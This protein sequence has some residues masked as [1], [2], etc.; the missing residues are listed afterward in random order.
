MKT[1]WIELVL[2]VVAVSV[3]DAGETIDWDTANNTVTYTWASTVGQGATTVNLS[4][5]NASEAASREGA[6]SAS[7]YVLTKAVLTLNGNLSVAISYENT[8]ASGVN[9]SVSAFE[10]SGMNG[11]SS[12]TYQGQTS[13]KE[14][15]HQQLAHDFG[16]V[17]AGQKVSTTLNAA[18]TGAVSAQ[19]LEALEGFIGSGTFATTVSF[20]LLQFNWS[21]GDGTT[22]AATT[23]NA[24]MSV[25]Y[26][27]D[28]VPEPSTFA[29]FSLGAAALLVRRRRMVPTP[30]LG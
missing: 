14:N 23:R 2:L 4:Q 30:K 18:G 17:D 10:Y 22:T 20:D 19:F 6:G 13:A 25:L 3:S 8:T 16:Y 24:E 21:V 12:F 28:A 27:Y 29:L 5:F 15:Y 7:D 1:R 26:Y 9:V 11:A